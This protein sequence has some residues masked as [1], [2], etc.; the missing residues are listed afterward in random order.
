MQSRKD[1]IQA[2]IRE[3]DN[4]PEEY[5]K[6]VYEKIHSF[7]QRIPAEGKVPEPKEDNPYID[8]INRVKEQKDKIWQDPDKPFLA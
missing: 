3:I 2:I 6:E 1:L 8:E 5:L 4:M 7:S